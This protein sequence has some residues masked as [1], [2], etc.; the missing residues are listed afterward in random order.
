MS[1]AFPV[2]L[3]IFFFFPM[4]VRRTDLVQHRTDFYKLSQYSL[5]LL[6]CSGAE[7][8]RLLLHLVPL[9]FRCGLGEFHCSSSISIVLSR[10]DIFLASG[11]GHRLT[12]TSA[13]LYLWS[14][15]PQIL[16]DFS[17]HI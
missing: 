3:I 13:G 16:I 1:F 2:L 17:L 9:N 14:S 8:F 5:H 10:S 15:H 7:M 11:I 4:L 6:K 12:G